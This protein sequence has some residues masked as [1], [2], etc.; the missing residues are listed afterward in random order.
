MACARAKGVFLK[1][2]EMHCKVGLCD[3]CTVGGISI[4]PGKKT[5]N[6]CSKSQ[7]FCSKRVENLGKMHYKGMNFT[8]FFAAL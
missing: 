3:K 2:A 8:N 1:I 6:F 4:N 5:K 7:I